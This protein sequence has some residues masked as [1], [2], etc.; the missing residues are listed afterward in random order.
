MKK[1]SNDL[2]QFAQMGLAALLPGMTYML[3]LMTRAVSEKRDLLGLLQ[4]GLPAMSRPK[5]KQ[6]W[7]D[8]PEERS[9]EMKR[10]QQVG[11]LKR[12][13]G[14]ATASANEVPIPN[15]PRNKNHPQHKLWL[16]RIKK[17]REGYWDKLTPAQRVARLNQMAEGKRKADR[18]RMKAKRA[19]A[20]AITPVVTMEKT[21]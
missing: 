18:E 5:G 19:A 15:H 4:E 21:A 16:K 7:S 11:R 17:S 20:K 2:D 1:T 13:E 10:R 14:F 6:G 9:R 12:G 8:D 3:E